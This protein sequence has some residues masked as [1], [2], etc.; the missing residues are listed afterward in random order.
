MASRP[1]VEVDESAAVRRLDAA[2]DAFPKETDRAVGMAA[3]I[4]KRQLRAAVRGRS[5]VAPVKPKDEVTV[6]LHGS[7]ELGGV[8][9]RP[10]SVRV[11]REGRFARSVGP[12][13]FLSRVFALWQDG[14]P[15]MVESPAVRHMM[16]IRLGRVRMGH[17]VAV[18]PSRYEGRPVVPA[19]AADARGKFRGWILGALEKA[20]A[21]RRA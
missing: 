14:G 13:R 21:K 12:A 20:L 2:A 1:P 5:A 7:G 18:V 9:G 19:L 3:S 17:L 6:I 15:T 10:S 4:I 16:H 8:L 11:R